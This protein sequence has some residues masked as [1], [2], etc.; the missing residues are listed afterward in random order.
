MIYSPAFF[1]RLGSRTLSAAYTLTISDS[2]I[3]ADATT[4]AFTATLPTAIG[5][6]G[7][8]YTIKKTD[9]SA[10]AVTLGTTSAQTIDGL[11][12]QSL[13]TQWEFLLVAS[14]GANWVIVGND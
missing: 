3:L 1:H 5:A 11:T 10:N 7:R 9:S 13:A 14:D 6:T 4:A 2:V 12:T 8:Q